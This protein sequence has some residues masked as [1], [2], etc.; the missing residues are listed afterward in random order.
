[1]SNITIPS[2]P[3]RVNFMSCYSYCTADLTKHAVSIGTMADDVDRPSG[4]KVFQLS[5]L[6]SF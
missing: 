3:D 1:M 4:L 6:F 5:Q 2:D